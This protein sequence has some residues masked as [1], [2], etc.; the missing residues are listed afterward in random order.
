MIHQFRSFLICTLG[1]GIPAAILGCG[2]RHVETSNNPEDLPI[3]TKHEWQRIEA[4]GWNAER[5]VAFTRGSRGNPVNV[6]VRVTPPATAEKQP[7]KINVQLLLS[8]KVDPKFSR[9]ATSAPEL[10]DCSK[11]PKRIEHVRRQTEDSSHEFPPKELSW[12]AVIQDPF[13]S[14]TIGGTPGATALEPGIYDLRVTLDL[15]LKDMKPF[16][17]EPIKMTFPRKGPRDVAP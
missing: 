1:V 8:H 14:N 7:P 12:E 6:W 16:V 10:V 13:K 3:M 15:G 4:N 2:P 11:L 5:W 17:F 9:K